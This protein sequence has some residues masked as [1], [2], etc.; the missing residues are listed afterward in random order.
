[1]GVVGVRAGGGNSVV[2]F[3]FL[4]REE[5]GFEGSPRSCYSRE[6]MPFSN[7]KG[8]TLGLCGGSR[9]GSEGLPFAVGLF[10]LVYHEEVVVMPLK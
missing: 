2:T 6:F 9:C 10:G 8:G 1:M 3:T 7:G 5:R 4:F